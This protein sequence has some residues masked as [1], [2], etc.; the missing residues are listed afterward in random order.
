M[1]SGAINGDGVRCILGTTKMCTALGRWPRLPMISRWVFH[2]FQ[3]KQEL[4][5]VYQFIAVLY[6]LLCL[7]SSSDDELTECLWLWW[8]TV[9]T[10]LCSALSTDGT[11]LPLATVRECSYWPCTSASSMRLWTWVCSRQRHGNFELW[12][13]ATPSQYVCQRKEYWRPI[14]SD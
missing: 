13:R 4:S 2:P 6:N 8:L 12:E 1:R 11:R 9:H 14:K 10:V 7:L 3:Y 5:S